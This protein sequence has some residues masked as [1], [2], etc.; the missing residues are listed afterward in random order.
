MPKGRKKTRKKKKKPDTWTD[1]PKAPNPTM[2]IASCP[3]CRSTGTFIVK[4]SRSAKQH[5][6]ATCTE[7][8]LMLYGEKA[9]VLYIKSRPYGVEKVEITEEEYQRI[10][11][12]R[13]DRIHFT[14]Q[15]IL[16]REEHK[17]TEAEEIEN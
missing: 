10:M 5:L 16:F 9:I 15:G 7:C 14:G 4:K 2:L 8:R 13:R 6:Y 11:N 1:K 17:P 12:V 3:C